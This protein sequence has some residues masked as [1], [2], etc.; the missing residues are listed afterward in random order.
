MS[1]NELMLKKS[2]P[3]YL[4]FPAIQPLTL[5]TKRPFWS[6]MITTYKRT[7]YLGQA[8]KSV[9]TQGIDEHEIQIEVVDDCSP[10]E[11]TQEI[12]KIIQV[13]GKGRVT[14][15]RQ[16]DNVGIYANWNTCI[17]RA[18]G[19]WVHILSDDDLVMLNF[20]QAYRQQIEAYKCSMVVGQSVFIG[21]QEQWL[22]ISKPLQ[23]SDGLLDNAL[24]QL[25]LQNSIRTP[26][27][28]V[29][30]EAYEKVG[31]FTNSL[32]YAPDWEMWTRI[33][34][35][36]N[37]AYVKRPYS[38]FRNHDSSETSKLVLSATSVTDSLT[39]SKIIQSRFDDFRD[40]QEIQLSVNKWLSKGSYSFCKKLA[41]KGYYYSA[42]LHALW[43]IRLTSSILFLSL[44]NMANILFK[45][46][47]SSS[48]NLFMHRKV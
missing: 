23:A 15:Y 21:E 43:I 7:E 48:A 39:T 9:L 40:R 14:F 38:Q 22:G 35:N 5:E 4:D 11:I 33:A 17:N 1:I 31:G 27:I 30:R 25:S 6:V 46:L 10:P 32:V 3:K 42:W 19:H 47:K 41:K 18:L 28:V 16:P 20:Y 34:A 13:V 12:A 2:L 36:F 24:K 45:I 26:A 8:L 44:M 37:V 29:A